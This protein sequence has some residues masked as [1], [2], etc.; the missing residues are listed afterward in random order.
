MDEK[1][2]FLQEG[3]WKDREKHH[4]TVFNKTITFSESD[5]ADIHK[6]LSEI[7]NAEMKEFMLTSGVKLHV[8]GYLASLLRSLYFAVSSIY[9]FKKLVV[10]VAVLIMQLVE[11]FFPFPDYKKSSDIQDGDTGMFYVDSEFS[12]WGGTVKR[13]PAS[14][15]FPKTVQGICNLVKYAKQNNKKIRLSG[16]RHSWPDLYA[17][18]DEIQVAMLPLEVSDSLRNAIELCKKRGKKYSELRVEN[19]VSLCTKWNTEFQ[20][21]EIIKEY[22]EDGKKYA[23]VRVGAS[24]FG[25][26]LLTWCFYRLEHIGITSYSL[27]LDV[28]MSL[29]TYG[30]VCS[31]MSHGA[32]WEH[33]TL[34]D[35]IV[36]IEYVDAN[37]KH[38]SLDDAKLLKAAAGSLGMLGVL[39][40]ITF[41]MNEASF[42]EFQPAA[43]ALDKAIPNPSGLDPSSEIYKQMVSGCENNYYSEWFWFHGN[44]KAW[45]NGWQDNGIAHDW[46]GPLIKEEDQEFQVATTYLMQG[47]LEVG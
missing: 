34:S 16:F 25:L 14:T 28:I 47:I 40:H 8:S 7:Y 17:D 39:T 45:K 43:V 13:R 36:K 27:P 46:T 15:F 41:K 2:F 33:K 42:A 21:I 11:K 10:K 24:V 38:Q 12:N 4:C 6:K 29:N 30:G 3:I 5:I 35:L 1:S 31:T 37:G 26:Q 23:N 20:Q 44:Q 22:E 32:G 18:N 9:F 19:I